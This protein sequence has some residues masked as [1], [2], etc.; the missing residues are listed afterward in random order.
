M[1][2]TIGTKKEAHVTVQTN[3]IS[4]DTPPSFIDFK[5]IPNSKLLSSPVLLS[6]GDIHLT[7]PMSIAHALTHNK[8]I[9]AVFCSIYPLASV[10]R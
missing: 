7:S 10:F 2:Y 5:Q 3:V 9:K 8:Y 1:F 6:T 4:V